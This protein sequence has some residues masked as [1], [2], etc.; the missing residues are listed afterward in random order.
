MNRLILIFFTN[1]Q[2]WLFY[3]DS[4]FW[5]PPQMK[6]C[7]LGNSSHFTVALIYALWSLFMYFCIDIPGYYNGL[8]WS[9][10]WKKWRR[11]NH[12]WKPV[13]TKDR[14]YYKICEMCTKLLKNNLKLRQLEIYILRFTEIETSAAAIFTKGCLS[15]VNFLRPFFASNFDHKLIQ[16]V[17]LT[18]Y[19]VLMY[20]FPR[21]LRF[22]LD[23]Y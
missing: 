13:F 7:T 18:W 16:L 20:I 1:F 22:K 3:S 14:S 4:S 21:L 9:Y 11:D 12:K 8:V 17:S 2:G 19:L 15:A 6:V 23:L 5:Q 10:L